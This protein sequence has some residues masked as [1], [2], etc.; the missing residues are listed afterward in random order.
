MSR[1]DL[2]QALMGDTNS[3]GGGIFSDKSRNPAG[4]KA[5]AGATLTDGDMWKPAHVVAGNLDSPSLGTINQISVGLGTPYVGEQT[6][7]NSNGQVEEKEKA[8]QQFKEFMA[9][10]TTNLNW[11][12]PFTPSRRSVPALILGSERSPGPLHRR[13]SE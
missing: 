3:A 13:R 12:V 10:R 4:G 6:W 2:T 9:G 11:Q 7:R 5:A 8:I 1:V